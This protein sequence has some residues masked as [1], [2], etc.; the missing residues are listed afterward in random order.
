MQKHTIISELSLFE[1]R[2]T[3]MEIMERITVGQKDS[4]FT[5]IGNLVNDCST[6]LSTNTE[7]F[8]WGTGTVTDSVPK[9]SD[10]Y[11]S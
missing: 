10:F 2:L 5:D 7:L 4:N 3:K 11:I 6:L 9:S 1:N 8:L